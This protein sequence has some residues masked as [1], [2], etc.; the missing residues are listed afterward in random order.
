MVT[1]R[2]PYGGADQVA[3]ALV[4]GLQTRHEVTFITTGASDEAY[5]EDGH[6]RIVIGLPRFQMF[7]HHYR[8]GSVVRKLKRRLAEVRPDVVH[9]HSVA[10]RTFSAA[11][12]LVS[13][14]YPTFWSL[15][16]VWSQCIWS[17]AHPPTCSGM[18]TGCA[19]CGALPVLSLFNRWFKESVF[20]RA[21]L[22][23]VVP[24]LWLKAHIAN[25]ALARKRVHVI[26]NGIPIER[27]TGDDGDRMRH[28]LGIPRTDRVVLFVGQMMSNWKGY[29][30]LLRMARRIL[31]DE[32][33][34][35]FLFVGP[36]RGLTAPHPRVV[37]M[38]AV[39]Y[40]EVP[41]CYAAGDVFAYPTHVDISPQVV[42]EAMASGLPQVTYAVG[43]IPEQVED[44]R[45]GVLVAPGDEARFETALMDLLNDPD[46]RRAMGTAARTRVERLFS[47]PSA[48]GRHDRG[49][50]TCLVKAKP[51]RWSASSCPPTTPHASSDRRS[52]ACWSRPT[53]TGS[54]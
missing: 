36:H 7:W 45:T 12:L 14:D 10:N 40:A 37:F 2:Y 50:N 6:R 4:R 32:E 41:D 17:A 43:G 16:D 47:R 30:D 11:A 19:W 54:W 13:R 20:R 49:R 3:M 9:F 21:D 1:S 31:T 24:C 23:V 52:R 46:R 18:L 48:P 15:H 53:P 51:T 5:D 27:F 42:L 44:G 8:N 26:P 33:D 28:K 29:A 25:S 38:G 22:D 35:W 39:P 34:V